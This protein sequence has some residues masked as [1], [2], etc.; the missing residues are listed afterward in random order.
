MTGYWVGEGQSKPVTSAAFARTVLLPLKVAAITVVSEE[1]VRSAALSAETL[2]RDELARALQAKVDTDFI[3]PAKAAVANVSPASITN[4][5]TPIASSGDLADDV[6]VDI[7]ALMGAFIAA[8]SPPKS[9]VWIMEEGTAI[10]LQLMT[11]ALGTPEFPGITLSGGTLFG[12]PIITSEY[13]TAGAVWL[14]DAASIWFADDGGLRIDMSR[15]ASL[16]MDNAPTN[17]SGP[18]AVATSVVSLWQTD[19]IGWRAEIG[20]ELGQS[21]CV[22][23][24]GPERRV[25]GHPGAV[26]REVR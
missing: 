10:Q 20:S 16:Q 14:V 24:S 19:S 15:E 18:T 9:G 6:R 1:L 23:C 26:I 4:G 17:A 7:A 8:N 21:P 22:R 5:V 11:T 3:D 25:V 2:L 13:V 12:M